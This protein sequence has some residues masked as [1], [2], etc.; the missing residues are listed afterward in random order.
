[1]FAQGKNRP[2]NIRIFAN[3]LWMASCLTFLTSSPAQSQITSNNNQQSANIDVF[4]KG[5]DAKPLRRLAV[6]SLM[7]QAGE[8]YKE[9]S[10]SLGHVRMKK[11]V[12]SQYTLQIVAPGFLTQSN[13][14][15]IKNSL[16]V[17]LTIQLEAS[18]YDE[19]ATR[20]RSGLDTKTQNELGKAT[21][22]IRSNNISEAQSALN[23]ADKIAPQNPEVQ[24]VLGVFKKQ[25]G[26]GEEAKSHWEKALESD[27]EHY[28]ALMAMSE[29]MLRENRAAEAVPYIERSVNAVPSAWRPHA[30]Y[31][32][33]Y[34]KQGL[35][36]EAIEQ[37]RL[38]QDLGHEKTAIVQPILAAALAKQGHAEEAKAILQEYVNGHPADEHAKKQLAA[39][40]APLTLSLNETEATPSVSEGIAELLPSSW[41]P[42]D[43]D[44]KVGTLE[45]GAA[46]DLAEVQKRTAE[47]IEEFLQNV[48]RFTAMESLQH[49]SI[50]KWGMASPPINRVFGYVVEIKELKPGYFSVDEYRSSPH[51]LNEY[52]EGIATRGVPAM[53]LIF[54]PHNA[55][56]FEMTCEGRVHWSGGEAWQLYFRQRADRPNTIRSFRVGENGQSYPIPLK[57]RALIAADTFQ[58]VR[59]ETQMI[60]PIREIN[61]E[62]DYTAIEYGQVHF[63]ATNT[64]LWLPQIAE[65]F[66]DKAGRRIHQSHTFSNYELFSVDEK[67]K[68]A[69]PRMKTENSEEPKEAT[70]KRSP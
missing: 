32:E 28:R 20:N 31:A 46:C 55:V 26:L 21:E 8:R 57:G 24:Y 25:K 7:K 48:D 30:L 35:T 19:G 64:N 16:D 6:V 5:P 9:G 62:A 44:E 12:P 43:I 61:L 60:A 29:A 56:N 63:N 34:L 14:I 47:R 37:A 69:D 54:H 36:T 22:A 15:E 17:K 59:L 40:Q 68:I 27:P 18:S 4:I 45:P 11:I 10:T 52:A 51:A 23:K 33:A 39:L 50:N 42:P 53:I 49:E 41:M 65:V 66:S 1:M 13:Q 3:A 58:V 38:A 70:S 67:Q 2:W